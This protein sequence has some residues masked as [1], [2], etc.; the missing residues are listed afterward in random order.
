M[1]VGTQGLFRPYLKTFRLF[2][3][4]DSLPLGLRGC[5]RPSMAVFYHVNGKLQRAYYYLNLILI[6]ISSFRHLY[7]PMLKSGYSS[8]QAQIA[9]FLLSAFFHEVYYVYFKACKVY[10]RLEALK[11]TN[12][13]HFPMKHCWFSLCFGDSCYHNQSFLNLCRLCSLPEK[14]KCFECRNA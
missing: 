2:S 11:E 14:K 3:R 6:L 4:P 12:S 13:P 1:R 9:V 5:L 10:Y 7:L 8:I